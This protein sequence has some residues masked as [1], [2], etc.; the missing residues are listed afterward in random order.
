MQIRQTLGGKVTI[1]LET[2]E[3]FEFKEIGRDYPIQ[4]CRIEIENGAF[5]V[6][7]SSTGGFVLLGKFTKVGYP[8]MP[9]AITKKVQEILDRPKAEQ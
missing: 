2:Y 4:V 8:Y 1:D 6:W 9:L 7:G 3:R 5:R